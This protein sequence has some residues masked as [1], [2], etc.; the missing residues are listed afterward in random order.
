M[1]KIFIKDEWD[2]TFLS[3]TV[4]KISLTGFYMVTLEKKNSKYLLFNFM[5]V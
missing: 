2:G 4:L 1:M 3:V 5:V